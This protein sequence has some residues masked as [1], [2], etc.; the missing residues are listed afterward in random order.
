MHYVSTGDEEQTVRLPEEGDPLKAG[1][2]QV[3]N[4]RFLENKSCIHAGGPRQPISTDQIKDT[5]DCVENNA[6]V[7][8]YLHL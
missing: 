1:D 4:V 8:A 2:L 3:R 7:C 6:A 5:A